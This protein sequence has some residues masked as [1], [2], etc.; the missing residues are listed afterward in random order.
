MEIFSRY[1]SYEEAVKS[2]TAIR[3]GIDNT[4]TPEHLANMKY[5]AR[6]IFDKVREFVKGPLHASSFYRS[7]ALND[8]VPGS[9][10]TSQHMKGE[11]I[12]IDCDTFGNGTNLKVFF[13]IKDN[14]IFDEL[15]GEYPDALGNFA[16]VHVSKSKTGNRG[17]VLVKLKGPYINF[18][19]YQVGM[20]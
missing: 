18:E 12:D 4:P 14:L 19:N 3:L 7:Q 20:V 6:E 16:W 11:A 15:I 2:K 8:M 5:V 17:R 9:S 10:K 13:F 1:L